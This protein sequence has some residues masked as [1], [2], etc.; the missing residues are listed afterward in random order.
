[1]V[2]FF[3]RVVL[4]LFFLLPDALIVVFWL[5]AHENAW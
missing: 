1:M 3:L 5:A 4:A 2:L